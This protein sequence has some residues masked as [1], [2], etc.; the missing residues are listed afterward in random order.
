[1]PEPTI[2]TGDPI[3][4]AMGVGHHAWRSESACNLDKVLEPLS[5]GQGRALMNILL[6]CATGLHCKFEADG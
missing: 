3:L 2:P 1:M 4:E 5:G 6:H